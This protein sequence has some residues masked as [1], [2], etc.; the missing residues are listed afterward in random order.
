M[1]NMKT[2]LGVLTILALL[3]WSNSSVVVA[4]PR[5]MS[6]AEMDAVSGGNT[7]TVDPSAATT[8]ASDT[9]PSLA[10]SS[11]DNSVSTIMLSGQA[12][13]N[14]TS[15]VNILSINSSVEVLLNLN[16]SINSPGSS[17][18]QGNTG[19]QTGVH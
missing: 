8:T 1:G 16:V 5:E 12:Q 13:Q 10:S 9:S 4:A 6:D 19:T 17:I 11:I 2:F 18:S 15:M 14:L 3:S 7:P